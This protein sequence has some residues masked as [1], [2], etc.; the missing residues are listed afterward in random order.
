[1]GREIKEEPIGEELDGA[2]LGSV[3]ASAPVYESFKGKQ[4]YGSKTWQAS[5]KENRTVKVLGVVFTVL[6][7]LA[8]IATFLPIPSSIR[9]LLFVLAIVSGIGGMGGY[10]FFVAYRH[11]KEDP[12]EM[13]YYD[14]DYAQNHFTGNGY[15][16]T[17]EIS[18]EEFL[19]KGAD[20]D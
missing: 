16:N 14:V 13:H 6:V 12:I 7:V 18:K 4:A 3:H 10:L 17:R 19:E 5:E 2:A 20:G 11:H 15:D 9:V 1:M 8:L